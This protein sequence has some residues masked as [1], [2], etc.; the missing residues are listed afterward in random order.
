M[1]IDAT[2]IVAI[3]WE[4]LAID[5][6]DATELLCSEEEPLIPQ[7]SLCPAALLLQPALPRQGIRIC[8]DAGLPRV[9]S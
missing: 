8:S 9:Y 7:S 2:V 1:D 6:S 3:S 4:S 5:F